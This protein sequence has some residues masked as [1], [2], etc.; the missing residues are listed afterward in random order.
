MIFIEKEISGLWV[1]EAKPVIDGRGRFRRHFCKKE[2][3]KRGIETRIVQTNISENNASFTLRGFHYQMKPFEESKTIS[4]LKGAICNV[5]VDLRP[6]SETFLKSVEVKLTPKNMLSLHVPS[7]CANAYLTLESNTMI[8][9]CMSEYYS[10]GSYTGF[11]YNDPLFNIKWPAEPKVIS[12]KDKNFPDFDP[13][14]LKEC[15]VFNLHIK[16]IL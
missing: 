8:F 7:G 6:E 16:T 4:C 14:S 11:R 3:E 2:F 9:Y 15:M 5:V 10:E 12:E 13:N 1:I